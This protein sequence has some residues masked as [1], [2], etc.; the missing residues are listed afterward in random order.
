MT[1]FKINLILN[2]RETYL[3]F[4]S[5]NLINQEIQF[6]CSKLIAPL[7]ELFAHSIIFS[8]LLCNESL[9]G[10]EGTNSVK[11]VNGVAVVQGRT[12]TLVERFER[13]EREIK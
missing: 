1:T 7:A 6:N 9:N 13:R 10:T 3:I 2:E 8:L 12:R 4:L 11:V 5:V